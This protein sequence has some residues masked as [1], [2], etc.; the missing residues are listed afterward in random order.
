MKLIT[1]LLRPA[2]VLV[3]L[4][5]AAAPLSATD[6]TYPKA[7]GF[8]GIWFDLGQKSKFGSKYSGGLGTYTANHVP[9]AHYAP[10][11]NR[12]YF[13]WGGTT[14]ADQKRL[15]IMVSYYD[16]STGLV[17]RPVTVM[18]KT[19]VN[20]PHDNGSLS[21]DEEGYLWIFVSGRGSKR[22][23]RIYRSQVPYGINDWINLGD[24]EFTY[25]Q[26][27]WFEGKGFFHT[28]TRYTKGREL[29]FRTSRKG[30]DW[31]TEKKLAGIGGHYQT[32]EQVGDR[33]ITAF[34]RHPGGV[35]DQRTD[36]YYMETADMGET[37]TTAEGTVLTTP[38][39][40]AANPAR[41]RNYSSNPDPADNALV[42]ICDTAADADGHPV[43]LYITA[44]KHQPGPGGNPRLWMIAR[45]TGTE[46]LFH[47]ITTALHN[48]DM[49]SIYIEEDGTWKVIAP[50]GAGPQ[51]WG[52]G[53][54]IELWTSADQGATWT[55][56]REITADSPRNHSYARRPR[57]AHPD[58]YAYWADGNADTLSESHLW[59]TNKAG[60]KLWHLPYNMDEDF[61][62]PELVTPL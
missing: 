50:I 2:I 54:E 14:E 28:Y 27:W 17:A 10:K 29:Y 56:Q 21:I 25:P 30:T 3:L 4:L 60:D 55:K 24:S 61:A 41:I 20:D 36:L 9:M 44:K 42:Y 52:T 40:T 57:N 53:G 43:I 16:H 31:S 1:K 33:V 49:G 6:A 26:P 18:D 8:R 48:Y 15:L 23:G 62:A 11:V 34:N 47:E 58:F 12:S 39:T 22:P 38:L 19:P 5:A 37:W 45:W 13:T 7:D 59:F 51:H 32:S 46:W 35:V